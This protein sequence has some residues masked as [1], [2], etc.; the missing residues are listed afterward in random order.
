MSGGAVLIVTHKTSFRL[1]GY[2]CLRRRW[3]CEEKKKINSCRAFRDCWRSHRLGK[4][5]WGKIDFYKSILILIIII[6]IVYFSYVIVRLSVYTNSL[7]RS[8]AVLYENLFIIIVFSVYIYIYRAKIKRLFFPLQTM[9]S[10]YWFCLPVGPV[11]QMSRLSLY[12]IWR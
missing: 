6:I 4:A 2:P 12:N 10:V 9:I 5:S 1:G 11:L 7:K 3:Y 8:L